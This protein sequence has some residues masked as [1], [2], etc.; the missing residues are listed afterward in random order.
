MS[1]PVAISLQK[2]FCYH[3]AD[4]DVSEP[5]LWVIGFTIDG[6]TIIHA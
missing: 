6:R 5:Y 1:I 2:L 3:G 4:E